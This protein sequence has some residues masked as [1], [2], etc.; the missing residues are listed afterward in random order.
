MAKITKKAPARALEHQ[1]VLLLFVIVLHVEWLFKAQSGPDKGNFWLI[2][3]HRSV[4]SSFGGRRNYLKFSKAPAR[5]P[6]HQL[7]LCI[8]MA[9][10]CFHQIFC[11]NYKDPPGTN[12]N[13]YGTCRNFTEAVKNLLL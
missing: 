11:Q 13:L 5:A 2:L 7:V 9:M 6:E 12:N 1:L 10:S 4:M 8:F 3:T